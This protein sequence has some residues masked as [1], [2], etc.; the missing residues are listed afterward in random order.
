MFEGLLD[1]QH[2][3]QLIKLLYRTA[4]WHGLAK[5]RLHTD[6]S[7]DLLEALTIEFGRLMRQFRDVTCSQFTTMELPRETAARSRS[8][9]QKRKGLSLSSGS[10]IQMAPTTAPLSMTSRSDLVVPGPESERL[11]GTPSDGTFISSLVNL[12]YSQAMFTRF[13]TSKIIR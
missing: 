2:D 11:D 8:E 4:E 13:P 3:K 1:G 5:L 10:H 9:A 7:L 6:Q 12:K